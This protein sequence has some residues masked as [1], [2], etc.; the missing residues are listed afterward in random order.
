MTNIKISSTNNILSLIVY[1]VYIFIMGWQIGLLM[2]V[3][4]PLSVLVSAKFG[5]KIKGYADIQKE[6][7]GAY[8]GWLFEMLS[9]IRDI[10]MLGAQK[11]VDQ[12]FVK[13]HRQLYDINIKSGVS[14]H[15]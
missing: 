2:L 9:G 7:F 5:K 10:R 4:V 11:R 8:N 3:T 13:H 1:L 14:S 6:C 15:L 12:E